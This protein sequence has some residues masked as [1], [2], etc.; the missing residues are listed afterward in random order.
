MCIRDRYRADEFFDAWVKRAAYII[1][2]DKN[3]AEEIYRPAPL[4]GQLI[5][6]GKPK[7]G[8]QAFKLQVEDE[9]VD[10]STLNI[11]SI[12]VSFEGRKTTP[13]GSRR[14]GEGSDLLWVKTCL[15]YTSSKDQANRAEKAYLD[16]LLKL[17]DIYRD[18]VKDSNYQQ[19]LKMV[20][21]IQ[22]T[23]D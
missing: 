4:S 13:V 9:A 12:V 2:E 22:K 8:Y 17:H 14:S 10:V 7:D 16:L 19:I 6:L 21:R 15:L 3:E 18:N 23:L 5:P 11:R 1:F 20:E